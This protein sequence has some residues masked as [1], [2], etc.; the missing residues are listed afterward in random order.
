MHP[1]W[2][3]IVQAAKRRGLTVNMTTNGVLIE[4]KMVIPSQ[5][6][7]GFDFLFN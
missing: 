3:E 7:L 2:E 5:K 6:R 1:E 4:K